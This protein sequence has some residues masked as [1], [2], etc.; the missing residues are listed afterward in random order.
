MWELYKFGKEMFE[1]AKNHEQYLL[2]IKKACLKLLPDSKV[3]LFGSAL[4]GDLVAGSDVDLLIVTKKKTLSWKKRAEIVA[5]IEAKL[6][7]PIAHPFE[8]HVKTENEYER[9]MAIY[10]PRLKEI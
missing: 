10:N 3:Y 2:P 9:F 8:F 4:T 5:A 7:L 6:A 1:L